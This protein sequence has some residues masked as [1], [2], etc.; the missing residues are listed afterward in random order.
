MVG[1]YVSCQRRSSASHGSAFSRSL[2]IPNVPSAS[3]AL[4]FFAI[5]SAWRLL[6]FVVPIQRSFFLL[7]SHRVRIHHALRMGR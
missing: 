1:E 7:P 4:I 6:A 5:S 3:A 2:S